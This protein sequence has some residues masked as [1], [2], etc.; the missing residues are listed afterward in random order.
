VKAAPDELRQPY[1]GWVFVSVYGSKAKL[2]RS[3]GKDKNITE[4]AFKAIKAL[5]NQVKDQFAGN[6]DS[7]PVVVQFTEVM[8]PEELPS[9]ARHNFLPGVDGIWMMPESRGEYRLP[10][11]IMAFSP[12]TS[13][14]I[15]LYFSILPNADTLRRFR[16]KAFLQMKAN[17][18]P[19]ELTR[20]LPPAPQIS[21]K[22]LEERIAGGC[23]YLLRNQRED[24]SYK[25][26]YAANRDKFL[27]VE[28]ESLVRQ[29]A[30][31]ASMA[32]AGERLKKPEFVESAGRCLDFIKTKIRREN[33]AAYL[34]KKGEGTLGGSAILAWAISHYA[35][36]SGKDKHDGIAWE[37]ANFLLGMQK[38]DGTFYNYFDPAKGEPI[39]RPARYYQG[40]ACLGLYWYYNFYGEKKCLD[41]ALRATHELSRRRN[42][43]LKEGAPSLD[44]WL[45]QAVRYLYPHANDEQKKEM[46]EAVTQMADMMV[47]AQRSEETAGYPDLAGSFRSATQELPSGPGTAAMCEGLAAACQ[48]FKETGKPFEKYKTALVN[49]AS[50]Q[51]RHQF[52]DASMYFLPNPARAR[53]SVKGTLTD[54]QVRI[55]H[56]QHSAGAW[57][58]LL[59]ILE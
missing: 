8:L 41:A 23:E 59:D 21:R 12:A 24:G 43:E 26:L 20:S 36:A 40:E 13:T 18:E 9:A 3:A 45:M 53:G 27:Q 25:Y 49:S 58:Q 2:F 35:R 46:L 32:L 5:I 38:P 29:T 56:V 51:L 37:A 28:E 55:D 6:A 14:D 19:V 15:A 22:L 39:D 16:T 44:A 34:L 54:N 4:G 50:F 57:L 17:E 42:K 31:A 30:C 33:N 47:E 52:W 11:E 1:D 10:G 48:L 7:L